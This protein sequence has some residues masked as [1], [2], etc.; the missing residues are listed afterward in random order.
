MDFSNIKNKLTPIFDQAKVYGGKALDFTQKQ[1]QGTP[2]FLKTEEAYNIHQSSRRAIVIG[3]DENNTLSQEVTL[4][5]PVWSAKA[6]MDNAEIRYIALSKT[7]E[8]AQIINMQGP[9]EMRVSY[10]GQEYFRTNDLAEMKQWW[11][12]RC[13]TAQDDSNDIESPV[14]PQREAKI[15]DPLEGK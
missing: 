9:V 10:D 3:Y 5:A 14:A 15:V 12:N 13:Y 2:I 4:R 1:A 6:W 7:P 8:L 11:E